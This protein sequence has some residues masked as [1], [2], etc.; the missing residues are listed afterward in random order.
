MVLLVIDTQK[1]ITNDSLFMFNE[2]IYNIELLINAS[3]ENCIEVIYVVH[4][5]GAESDLTMGKDGF[6]IYE[7]FKPSKGEKI[8]VKTVNSAFNNTGLLEYL[9]SKNVKK[10]IEVRG[11]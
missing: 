5:D 7:K 8:F 6:E 11:R 3:R 2:V 10:N 4:D 1:L 9:D